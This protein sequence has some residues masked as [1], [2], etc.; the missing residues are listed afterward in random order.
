MDDNRRFLNGVSALLAQ[1][2]DVVGVATDGLQAL[3]AVRLLEPDV[4]VLDV[5][6]PKFD[7]L[8]TCRALRWVPR[9]PHRS[10]F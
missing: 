7:G 2:F 5:D 1:A 3:D 10:C 6:M 4:I 9:R 8:Q